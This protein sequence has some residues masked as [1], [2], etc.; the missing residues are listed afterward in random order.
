[1]PVT[2]PVE[3]LEDA[4]AGANILPAALLSCAVEVGDAGVSGAPVLV[5]ATTA[6][7][8]RGDADGMPDVVVNVLTLG[9]GLDVTDP[10]T[11]DVDAV[12]G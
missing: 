12:D 9:L 4:S 2:A 11:G 6:L 8:A 7:V 10:G 3:S 1:M 5:A